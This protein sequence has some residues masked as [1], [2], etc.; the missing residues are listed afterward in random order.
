MQRHR[1][2]IHFNQTNIFDKNQQKG[3]AMAETATKKLN[4]EFPEATEFSLC[5]V[6]FF[7]KS[8]DGERN[9]FTQKNG[10][11]LTRA[12]IKI[13]SYIWTVRKNFGAHVKLTVADIARACG[14]TWITAKENLTQLR[15]LDNLI[16]D[17]G[18]QYK[19]IPKVNGSNYFTVENYLLTKKFDIDGTRRKLPATAVLILDRLKS[20]YLEVDENGEYI[21]YDFKNR[22]PKNYFYS[23]EQGL[24]TLL[25]LPKSTIAYNI[26]LLLKLKLLYRNKRLKYK[27]EAGKS[28]YKI[29]QF[30]PGNT[31][32]IFVVPYEVLAVELRSTYEPQKVDFIE[33]ADEIEITDEALEK[34]YAELRAEAEAKTAAARELAFN[35][36]E[37]TA[38]KAELDEAICTA[39]TAQEN[40][41]NVQEAKEYWD[42][43][44]ARYLKRLAELG[45]TEEEISEPPYLCRICR[46]TGYT[47]TGQRCRC[48]SRVKELII[49]R[50][51]KRK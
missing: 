16:T 50:M 46:D 47:N 45:I 49:S 10:K 36:K 42:T 25:N 43:A 22:K 29:V 21:N 41:G 14:L 1:E 39:F 3:R 33:N 13:L 34:V 37:L 8:K 18:K 38:V 17:T 44:Q 27:N 12:K 19:I 20:F 23:S 15:L 2:R 7:G 35:D 5:P 28:V 4:T 40:G 6:Q 26:P 9:P 48:R 31:Q 32:S 11:P 51:F 30:V 24:A